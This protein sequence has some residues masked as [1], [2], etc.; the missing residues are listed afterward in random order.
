MLNIVKVI[1]DSACHFFSGICFTSKTV[2]LRPSCNAGFDAMSLHVHDEFVFVQ[3][4][5]KASATQ[6]YVTI[7]CELERVFSGTDNRSS[8]ALWA[9]AKMMTI[10]RTRTAYSVSDEYSWVMSRMFRV[11]LLN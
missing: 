1:S 11:A 8:A 3:I 2:N 4:I 10:S 9:N 5:V 6:K 7:K